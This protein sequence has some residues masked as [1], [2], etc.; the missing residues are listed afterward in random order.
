MNDLMRVGKM[1]GVLRPNET[2]ER[3]VDVA[4]KWSEVARECGVREDHIH[5]IKEN[6][7]FSF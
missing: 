7:L 1:M 3:I 6:L 5:L 4:S 2:I